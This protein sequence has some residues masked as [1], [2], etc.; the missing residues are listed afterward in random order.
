MSELHIDFRGETP[1]PAPNAPGARPGGRLILLA[2]AE[3]EHMDPAQTYI[4]TTLAVAT[5]LFHRTLTG[6]LEDPAGGPRRLVGDLATDAGRTD[7]G[8]RTWTYTLR[9]GLKYADG[10]PIRAQD[11]AY[12]VARSFS[13]YGVYGPQFLQ[14]ALAPDGGYDGPYADGAPAPGVETPDDRTIVFRLP[15]PEPLFPLLATTTT[16]TPVPADR[17]TRERYETDW[18]ATG[19][20]RVR[21]FVPGSHYLFERNPHWDPATDPIRSRNADE[22]RWEFGVDRDEQT[23]RLLH[24]AGDDVRA[25]ATFDVAQ[26]RV[27]EVLGDPELSR[28]VVA[29][30]SVYLQY[31]YINT[32]RVTDVDVRRA[33][34]F[35]I[36]RETL[37]ALAGGPAAAEPATTVLAPNIP[38]YRPYDAY[39][40]GAS[41]DPLRAKELLAGKQLRPLVFAYPDTLPNVPVAP[42]VKAALE[43]A[44][45]EIVPRAVDKAAFYSLMGDAEND[46]DLIYGVWGPDFPDASGVFDV[47][48]RGDRLTAAGNMNLSYFDDPEI[49]ARLAVLSREPDRGALADAYAEL[50]RDLMARHAPVVPV[51]YKRQLTLY[52]PAVG[53]LSLSAQYFVPNLTRAYVAG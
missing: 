31:I 21:E 19:P 49:T 1:T 30:P 4:G 32:R 3:P 36:D 50:D 7:D 24:P 27:D 9:E 16:T 17:D 28:R 41:G 34:N 25:I 11:V 38:G 8:G 12:A 44:G 51:Y 13:P 5:A 6:Y 53:G 42:A 37:V 40:A 20:Y 18:V 39:P 45:F 48:F 10:R 43:R 47:L 33:L 15:A 14:Q 26:D 22:I 52:G 2:D 23:R 46:C 35:A 29:G